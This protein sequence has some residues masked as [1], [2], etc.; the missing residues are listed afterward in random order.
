MSLRARLMLL[1]VAMVAAMAVVLL[2]VQTQTLVSIAV[3]NTLERANSAA[4]FVKNMVV[5][6]AEERSAQAPAGLRERIEFWRENLAADA[7][8]PDLLNSAMAQTAPIVEIAVADSKDRILACSNPQKRGSL[9]TPRVPLKALVDL[10]PLDRFLA[11]LTGHSD[12]EARAE[13]GVDDPA[14]AGHKQRVFVIQVQ[15]SPVLLRGLVLPELQRAALMSL[16][17]L[18]LALLMAWLAAG[19]A[20]RPLAGISKAIDRISSGQA[21]AV[22]PA[23]PSSSREFALVEE[24]LRLLGEQ[25]RGAQSGASALRGGVERM[26]ESLEE[27]ILLFNSSGRLMVC[28]ER[29]GRLLNLEHDAIVGHSAAEL[30]PLDGP[31]GAELANILAERR[32]PRHAQAGGLSLHVDFLPDGAWMLRLGDIKGRQMVESQLNLSS[33]LAA[34]SRLTG[35]VAHEIKN[36][37]NSIALRLEL[38]R[39]RVLPEVPEAAPEIEVIAQEITRLDRVVRTFLDFTRPTELNTAEL[40]LASLALGLVELLR[41]EAA[42]RRVTVETSGLDAPAPLLGD[43]DLLKQALM[44]VLRNSLEA[45]PEGGRLGVT[46]SRQA[47]ETVLEISD[48][49]PGIPAAL[50]EKIFQLYYTT[51][52]KGSGIGLAMTFRAVQ[53]HNGA[54]EVDGG[55]GQGARIRLRF[56]LETLGSEG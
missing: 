7:D 23:A 11:V 2:G 6:R 20:L 42:D 32:G 24:K 48:S 12:Y 28:S 54:I 37:L 27:A 46:L 15:V 39:S 10:G 8:L 45:M 47:G 17:L 19:I 13:L 4:Q 38:L 56:P 5:Q 31:I 40:D 43:A 44:N 33:R 55:E 9:L 14:Q 26:L 41:P 49:G 51:K 50:R 25:Y 1:I 53:L 29:A 3:Q 30:F 22:E 35:G 18:G 36:P 16:P 21:E 34:I 52:A